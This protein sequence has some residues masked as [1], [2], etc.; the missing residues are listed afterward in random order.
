M[1]TLQSSLSAKQAI[2]FAFDLFNEFFDGARRSNVLLEG[3]EYLADD[4]QWLVTIGF[5]AGREKETSSTLGFGQ[6][7]REP[8]RETRQFFLWAKDGSLVRMV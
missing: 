4:H 2:K 3:L 5:D 8:I 6:R 7:I 1:E